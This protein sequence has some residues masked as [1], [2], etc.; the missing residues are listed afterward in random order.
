MPSKTLKMVAWTGSFGYSVTPGNRWAFWAV[1]FLGCTTPPP[2]V[3]F[4]NAPVPLQVHSRGLKLGIYA[5]VGKN[6]CAGYPGSLGYYDTDAQ[7]FADWG[8]DL[9]KFDGCFMNWT[10]LGEGEPIHKSLT[11]MNSTRFLKSQCQPEVLG[12]TYHFNYTYCF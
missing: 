8:V 6:T 9:L 4:V 10:L 11:I 7:T 3:V 5:D 1:S 12:L 2:S